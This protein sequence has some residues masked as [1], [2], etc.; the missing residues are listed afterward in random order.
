MTEQER[1][2]QNDDSVSGDVARLEERVKHLE[3]RIRLLESGRRMQRIHNTLCSL[4]ALLKCKQTNVRTGRDKHLKAL[5]DDI[6]EHGLMEAIT[7]H[8]PTPDSPIQEW[9]V[10]NGGRRL[11]ALKILCKEDPVGWNS[12]PITL[13]IET[14]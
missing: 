13:L 2:E 4:K 11:K 10:V 6:R 8:S 14:S 12:V 1:Q 5:V 9:T 7:V 3:A